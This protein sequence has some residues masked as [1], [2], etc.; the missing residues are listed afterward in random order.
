MW[1]SSN[2][3]II[4]N[5]NDST[6]PLA[7]DPII[8]KIFYTEIFTTMYTQILIKSQEFGIGT[9]SKVPSLL[10]SNR[11]SKKKLPKVCS[12][13]FY[14]SQMNDHSTACTGLFI[15]PSMRRIALLTLLHGI[16]YTIETEFP[17]WLP[18]SCTDISSP[19]LSLF[20]HNGSSFAAHRYWR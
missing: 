4:H 16:E 13:H 10:R 3:I 5:F 7:T 1:A 8:S 11:Y 15:L 2:M 12:A 9:P 14:G 17:I 20:A 19:I 6:N 18:S